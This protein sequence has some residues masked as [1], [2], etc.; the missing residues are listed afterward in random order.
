M[1]GSRL[2]Q[3]F[4]RRSFSKG[5]HKPGMTSFGI[6][7]HLTGYISSPALRNVG[8]WTAG[9]LSASDLPWYIV[10]Q[11]LGGIT[12]A[13]IPVLILHGKNVGYDVAVTTCSMQDF[14]LYRACLAHLDG[15]RCCPMST[16]CRS[17]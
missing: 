15:P 6:K 5:G 13:G 11:V 9:R 10:A 14:L 2:R 8:A 16:P 17:L 4:A 1:R 12:G 7:P 3:G